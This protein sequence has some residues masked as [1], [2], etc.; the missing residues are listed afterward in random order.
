MPAKDAYSVITLSSPKGKSCRESS[1]TFTRE[2][3]AAGVPC[4]LDSARSLFVSRQLAFSLSG[5]IREFS[6]EVQKDF[7]GT[8]LRAP[9]PVVTLL[10]G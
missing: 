2:D 3:N 8:D 10:R 7:S 5:G 9:A 6:T 4:G 1:P